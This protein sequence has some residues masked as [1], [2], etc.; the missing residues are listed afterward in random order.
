MGKGSNESSYLRGGSSRRPHGQAC[1]GEVKAQV[2]MTAFRKR[3]WICDHEAL[4]NYLR[5]HRNF[6][7]ASL[8]SIATK[9]RISAMYLS[10]LERGKRNWTEKLVGSF[11]KCVG[12]K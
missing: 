7:G 2:L 9:M 10:D 12:E 11:L 4:G 6:F 5:I 1:E 8:R 3:I